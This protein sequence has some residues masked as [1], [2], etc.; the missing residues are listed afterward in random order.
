MKN[1]PKKRFC[2]NTVYCCT[3]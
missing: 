3:K 1:K 2:W